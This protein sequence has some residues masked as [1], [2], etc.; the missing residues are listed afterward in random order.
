MR[1]AK[2]RA[3]RLTASKELERVWKLPGRL[4]VA[5]AQRLTASKEL[6]QRLIADQLGASLWCSTP[7][8][9]KGIGTTTYKD[10]LSEFILCSTP[11]GIKGIGTR[12]HEGERIVP[13]QC[14]TP[15]GIK[16]IGTGEFVP[17]NFRM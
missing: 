11:Y 14:S 15:Y 3:Q 4:V 17:V 9:I 5:R 13:A 8:G 2:G 16:G 7:Y 12:V 1:P 6:E 10:Q